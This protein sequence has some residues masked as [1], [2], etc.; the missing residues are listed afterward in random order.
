MKMM[1]SRK[2]VLGAFLFTGLMFYMKGF[3]ALAEGG[4]H[5][6]G[7]KYYY[8]MQAF[9]I[10][11]KSDEGLEKQTSDIMSHKAKA[12]FAS[13]IIEHHKV[14]VGV[15]GLLASGDIEVGAEKLPEKQEFSRQVVNF[16]LFYKGAAPLADGVKVIF[17]AYSTVWQLD[18]EKDEKNIR[19]LLYGDV[20][21]LSHDAASHVSPFLGLSFNVGPGNLMVKAAFNYY[22]MQDHSLDK[23]KI[24][25]AEN[26][27]E[28]SFEIKDGHSMDA[29]LVYDFDYGM[30]KI[31]P[32][33]KYSRTLMARSAEY[34]K[35]VGENKTKIEKYDDIK[36]HALK[37][38][39]KASYNLTENFSL[40]LKGAYNV[41]DTFEYNHAQAN[42]AGAYADDDAVER[43]GKNSA[44]RVGFALHFM[45]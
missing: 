8:G 34:S 20:L 7:I 16:H 21:N 24:E 30:G 28:R 15:S 1:L 41:I 14:G 42:E 26:D 45:F 9:E 29:K 12:Y 31:S 25:G 43:K 3:N 17:G 6:A 22:Y 4:S 37:V 27:K 10:E 44:W 11:G 18:M 38:A 2:L 36:G 40:A 23:E 13:E 39:L 33:V 5:H 19:S 35:E 32:M